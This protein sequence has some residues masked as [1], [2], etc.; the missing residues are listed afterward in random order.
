MNQ[1]VMLR[2]NLSEKVRLILA[3]NVRISID[4][5]VHKRLRRLRRHVPTVTNL[6]S[7]DKMLQ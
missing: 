3:E 7:Q 4:Q 6:I 5:K 2:K 1:Y